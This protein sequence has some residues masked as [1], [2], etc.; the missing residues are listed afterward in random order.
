MPKYD[1]KELFDQLNKIKPVLKE[2]NSNLDVTRQ[3]LDSV[4]S[5]GE[6][7]GEFAQSLKSFYSEVHV[8]AIDTMKKLLEGIEKAGVSLRNQAVRLDVEEY[9][10][11]ETEYISP[12]GE[13]TK[14]LN[15]VAQAYDYRYKEIKSQIDLISDIITISLPSNQVDQN[16]SKAISKLSHIET[17]ANNLSNTNVVE[18]IKDLLSSFNS[19]LSYIDNCQPSDGVINYKT[20]DIKTQNWYDGLER[21]IKKIDEQ[22][23]NIVF[24]GVD[25]YGGNQSGP[26][27]NWNSSE[28]NK[29]KIR[30]LFPGKSDEEIQK[31]LE[32]LNNEGC[33]YTA[34]INVIFKKFEGKE[35]EFE[36]K[37][38]IPYYDENGNVNFNTLLI[39]FYKEENDRRAG[40]GGEF[41]FRHDGVLAGDLASNIATYCKNHGVDINGEIRWHNTFNLTHDIKD[42]VSRNPDK[43]FVLTSPPTGFKLRKVS[44]EEVKIAWHTVTVVGIENGRL[45]VSSWG[46]KYYLDDIPGGTDTFAY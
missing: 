2:M 21:N 17:K 37:F 39:D 4:I 44:G 14:D 45:V 30:K 28:N 19:L 16:I 25:A 42:D 20:G 34:A 24:R 13:Q 40:I 3:A 31:I 6:F 36:E 5:N 11:I 23:N 27:N 46:G 18:N 33:G 26:I 7:K 38:G 41:T 10:K 8:K 9:A 15:R 29:I 35:K 43:T 12:T 1:A 22:K 32:T